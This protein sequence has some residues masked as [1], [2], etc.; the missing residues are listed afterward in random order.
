MQTWQ[1]Q[2]SDLIDRPTKPDLC[3]P[4]SDKVRNAF[5]LFAIEM[6]KYGRTA[7]V[8]DGGATL[9]LRIHAGQELEMEI[10]IQLEVEPRASVFSKAVVISNFRFQRTWKPTDEGILR[11]L[12]ALYA[13]S[14]PVT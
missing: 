1:E 3:D 7:V 5:N 9:S 12:V 13:A 6:R 11:G 2:L 4:L 10:L 8:G 14:R